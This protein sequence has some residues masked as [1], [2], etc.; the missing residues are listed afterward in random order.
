[1]GKV[2]RKGRSTYEQHIRLHRGVTSSTA[3][4]TLSCEARA[5]LIEIWARH[6]GLNNGEISFSQREARKALRIGSKKVSRAFKQLTD[7]GF[8]IV[9]TAGSFNFK[10]GAAAG[11]ATEWELTTEQCGDKPAK[12]TYRTWQ[13]N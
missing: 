10:A 9:K 1:M 11:R 2:N 5:L 4:K 6:N 12:R 7:R 13:N 8:L 3:W